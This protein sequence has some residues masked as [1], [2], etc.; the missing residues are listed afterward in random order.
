MQHTIVID[1]TPEQE[2]GWALAV[3]SELA[4]RLANDPKAE[5]L[6][7]DDLMLLRLGDLS[8]SYASQVVDQQL[9]D[10]VSEAKRDPAVLAAAVAAVD[11]AKAVPAA[12][13]FI[14]PQRN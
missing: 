10:F 6:S 11:A 5:P 13:P 4:I 8:D 1:T 9:A 12:D 14:L 2:D 3:Q 7:V